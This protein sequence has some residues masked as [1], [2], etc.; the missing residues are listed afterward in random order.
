MSVAQSAVTAGLLGACR[1]KP[2]NVLVA[3]VSSRKAGYRNHPI[4]IQNQ[5]AN[6]ACIDIRNLGF[7]GDIGFFEW[8]CRFCG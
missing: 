4:D 6:E 8:P 1:G 5:L 3:E 2:I 7:K